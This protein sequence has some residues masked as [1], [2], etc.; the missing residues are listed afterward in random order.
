[1]GLEAYICAMGPHKPPKYP[2]LYQK[3]LN[4]IKPRDLYTSLGCVKQQRVAV[5]LFPSFC[6]G[7]KGDGH[8]GKKCTLF[9]DFFVFLGAKMNLNK[10]NST[11]N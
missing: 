9:E 4:K 10:K 1:M 7:I 11:K 2:L 3:Q 5:Q 6:I 8:K